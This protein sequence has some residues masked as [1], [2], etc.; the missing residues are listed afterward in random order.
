M[1]IKA[2]LSLFHTTY[3]AMCS[4]ACRMPPAASVPF[5][6]C[7]SVHNEESQETLSENQNSGGAL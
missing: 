6:L 3:S 7:C 4:G 1:H 5:P 2:L